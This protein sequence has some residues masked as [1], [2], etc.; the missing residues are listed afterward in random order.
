MEKSIFRHEFRA[1]CHDKFRND[2]VFLHGSTCIVTA[3]E[4]TNNYKFIMYV[5]GICHLNK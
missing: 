5:F 1:Y 3:G 2:L 4:S